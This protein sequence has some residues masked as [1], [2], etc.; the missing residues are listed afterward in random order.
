MHLFAIMS[1]VGWT[2]WGAIQAKISRLD[3]DFWGYAVGRWE[4][5]Q[6]M[7]ESPEFPG[8]LREAAEGA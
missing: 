4:R 1:D 5:A 7:M 6:R 2:L 8:W 3:F